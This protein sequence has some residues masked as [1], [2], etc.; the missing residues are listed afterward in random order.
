MS[1]T[2]LI[3]M[4]LVVFLP[5]LF[6]LGLLLFP[7]GWELSMCWWSLA[8]IALTLGVSIG[9][10]FHFKADTVDFRKG[11]EAQKSRERSSLDYR[12]KIA[13]EHEPGP[14]DSKDWVARYPWIERFNIQYYMGVDG[15][16]MP[17]ILLT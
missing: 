10:F 16:S 9:M 13:S 8:G 3:W 11:P 17:L 15:I 5:T 12:V 1:E 6:A 14:P 7:R 4:S 2:D